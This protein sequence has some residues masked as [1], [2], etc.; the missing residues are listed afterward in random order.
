MLGGGI[1]DG[2]MAADAAW[3][4]WSCVRQRP[5]VRGLRPSAELQLFAKPRHVGLDVALDVRARFRGRGIGGLAART[6]QAVSEGFS[7]SGGAA[8]GALDHQAGV[9][10]PGGTGAGL[11]GRWGGSLVMRRFLTK[12]RGESTVP[13]SPAVRVWMM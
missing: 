10:V 4:K 8:V 2:S 11:A 9:V 13:G 5:P 12:P 7:F 1:H 6:A 3:L